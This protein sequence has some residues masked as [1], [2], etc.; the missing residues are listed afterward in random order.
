MVEQREICLSF[1]FRNFPTWKNIWNESEDFFEVTIQTNGKI[2]PN[3]QKCCRH[4]I[5][6]FFSFHKINQIPVPAFKGLIRIKCFM[7][8]T[9]MKV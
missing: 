7:P 6:A 5:I 9:L 2:R 1:V 3:L 8:L 4:Q